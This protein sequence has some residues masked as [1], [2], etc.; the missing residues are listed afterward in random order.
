[1]TDHALH[2]FA[3]RRGFA[4]AVLALASLADDARTPAHWYWVDPDFV[5]WP[6]DDPALTAALAAW[7]ARPGR[8]LTLLA[9]GYDA[10]ARVHP[11]FVSW[12]RPR[13]HL[14]HG[15]Q[16]ALDVS[17]LPTLFLARAPRLLELGERGRWRGRWGAD[18]LQWR[19]GRELVG[20]L[21]QQAAPAFAVTTLGI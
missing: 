13:A 5:D 7:L 19:A 14:V 21:L 17:E 10:L 11:R 3:G 8:Q 12:R 18:A 2:A 1:M 6:L 16:V 9:G 15:L 20:A 4:D